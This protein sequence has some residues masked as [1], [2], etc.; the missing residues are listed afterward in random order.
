MRKKLEMYDTK[1]KLVSVRELSEILDIKEK[2]LYHLVSE[3]KIPYYRIG[4]LV[5]FKRD[6]IDSWIESKKSIPLKKR[7]DNMIRS[8][9]TPLKGRPG[10]LGKEAIDCLLK[11]ARSGT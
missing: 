2:T 11:E 6:E 4:K 3:G 10:R 8:T 9:Y 1:M 5:R 7:V